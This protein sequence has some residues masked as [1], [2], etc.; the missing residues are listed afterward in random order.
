MCD[1]GPEL[2]V[3]GE[4]AVKRVTWARSEA[5]GEFALEHENAAAGWVGE[6]EE[7]EY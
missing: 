7:F 3:Y 4:T 5:E 2:R 6:G 1:F